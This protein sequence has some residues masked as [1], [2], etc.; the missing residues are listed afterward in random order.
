MPHYCVVGARG[1][2]FFRQGM[3]FLT[4][5]PPSL[6]SAQAWPKGTNFH[7]LDLNRLIHANFSTFQDQLSGFS[8]YSYRLITST[9]LTCFCYPILEEKLTGVRLPASENAIIII[10]MFPVCTFK[11]FQKAIFL[12]KRTNAKV[13]PFHPP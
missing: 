1:W 6:N 5:T 4:L 3:S 9:G 12:L 7:S 11:V 10:A 13:V 2:I 8:G